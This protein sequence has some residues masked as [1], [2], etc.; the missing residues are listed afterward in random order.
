MVSGFFSS[1]PKILGQWFGMFLMLGGMGLLARRAYRLPLL[2]LVDWISSVWLGLALTI[3][4]LQIIHLFY[5][6]NIWIFV[7]LLIIG[8]YG[9]IL[10]HKGYFQN[11]PG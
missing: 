3:G 11:V 8:G 5:P 7:L 1:L 9:L 4:L 6:I 2:S 10:C